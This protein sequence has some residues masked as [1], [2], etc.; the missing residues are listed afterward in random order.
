L[1]FALL[2]AYVLSKPFYLFSDG[3]PQPADAAIV[4][5]TGVLLLRR[6]IQWRRPAGQLVFWA[7]AFVTYAVALNLAWWFVLGDSDFLLAAAYYLYN[8]AI[9]AACV[10]L[11]AEFGERFLRITAHAVALSLA[12]QVALSLVLETPPGQRA[13]LSFADPNQLGYW[14]VLSGCIF[15]LCCS[16]TRIGWGLQLFACGAVSYLAALSV[17]KGAVA[18]LVPLFAVAFLRSPRTLLLLGLVGV[19]LAL[20]PARLSILEPLSQRIENPESDDTIEG[21]GY[22]RIWRHPQHLLLG[23]GEGAYGRFSPSWETRIELHSSLGTLLFGYGA[24]GSLAFAGLLW[25]IARNG[26]TRGVLF[27]LPPLV[28]GLSHQGLRFS[29]FW[30]VLAFAGSA[31]LGRSWESGAPVHVPK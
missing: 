23:A 12:A 10:R 29:L 15:F 27:L 2:W 1:A 13:S 30:M 3:L 11:H 26:G 18:A 16:Q 25:R 24:L 7:A 21:R 14:S 17:S 5:L 31:G 9:L 22:D 19:V 6:R 28:Y 20:A 4:G 8:F